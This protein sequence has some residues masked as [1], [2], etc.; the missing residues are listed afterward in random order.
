MLV[1]CVLSTHKNIN[2]FIKILN[3]QIKLRDP[4]FVKVAMNLKI[5]ICSYRQLCPQS[6]GGTV[7][8]PQPS[9]ICVCVCVGGGARNQLDSGQSELLATR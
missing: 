8:S 5:S 2:C 3:S 7:H 6:S 9:D 4:M 1:F